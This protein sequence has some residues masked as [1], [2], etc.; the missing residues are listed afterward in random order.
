[1]AHRFDGDGMLHAVR[2]KGGQASYSNTYV[3]TAKLQAE[4][5]AG[6]PLVVTV[7]SIPVLAVLSLLVGDLPRASA[8]K[9]RA[10]NL[11]ASLLIPQLLLSSWEVWRASPAW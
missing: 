4:R 11:I 3:N 6:H 5:R 2:I 10:Q 1:M 7:S 9:V 8:G